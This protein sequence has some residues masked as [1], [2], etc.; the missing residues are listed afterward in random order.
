MAG[1]HGN[2][3]SSRLGCHAPVHHEKL[4]HLAAP[5]LPGP[6]ML[7]SGCSIDFIIIPHFASDEP[8]SLKPISRANVVAQLGSQSLNLQ[9]LGKPGF[10]T[11]VGVVRRV[12]CYSLVCPD[13]TQAVQLIEELTLL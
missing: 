3:S 4:R 13:L 2:L 12:Q 8:T 5:K 6:D 11:L 1:P 10:D 7:D 9:I